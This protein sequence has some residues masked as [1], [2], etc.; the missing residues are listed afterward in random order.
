MNVA[1]IDA[2]TTCTGVS[3]FTETGEH[4]DTAAFAPYKK[5]MQPL[6]AYP[7]DPR[8][9]VHYQKIDVLSKK[10][11]WF[12]NKHE[13]KFVMPESYAS[14]ALGK[15][16]LLAELG[17]SYRMFLLYAGIQ[18]MEAKPSQVKKF[19]TGKGNA[20]KDEVLPA[21]IKTWGEHFEDVPGGRRGDCA[22]AY[23]LG[24][25]AAAFRWAFNHDKLNVPATEQFKDPCSDLLMQRYMETLRLKYS[26]QTTLY[27][28]QWE[29]V[30][31]L[32]AKACGWRK[33]V[34]RSVKK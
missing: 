14:G 9:K 33:P 18:W 6:R 16:D 7:M 23:V 4:I 27:K 30:A 31:M 32:V 29:V 11:V 10:I 8:R 28:P 26:Y 22:D 25:I 3:V 20:G 12:L 17:G 2:S 19:V 1:G 13:V 15:T 5:E 34:K 21:V 24:K